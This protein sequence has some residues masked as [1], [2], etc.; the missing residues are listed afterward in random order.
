MVRK[1]E[2]KDVSAAL[3]LVNELAAFEKAPLEVEVSLAEMEKWGFGE[4]KIFDFFVLEKNEIIVGMA[5]Y[6]F[7]YSTWKGKCLFLEDLIIT[8]SQR[9]KGFGKL[10]F[11]EVV[12]VA[13]R[14]SVRRMEWQ[15]LDWNI[16][17]ID[18]YKTYDVKMDAD[19]INCKLTYTQIQSF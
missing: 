12:K 19:W 7:K 6:Y 13:K 14:E 16:S 9:G 15:V 8:E 3:K 11:D 10:L 1:G 18:F 17:A 5:L 4:E 2:I